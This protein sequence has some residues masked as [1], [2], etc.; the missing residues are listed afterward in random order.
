MN[1]AAM[2][3]LIIVVQFAVILGL[4]FYVR[5]QFTS[6]RMPQQ[7]LLKSADGCDCNDEE[8]D[9]GEWLDEEDEEDE[10]DDEDEEEEEED[11]KP[12]TPT[13]KVE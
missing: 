1:S 4:F 13:E 8:E 7:P 2:T 12:T 11:I 5:Y 6:L 3:R 9:D 10:E